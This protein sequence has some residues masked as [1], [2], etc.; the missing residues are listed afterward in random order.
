MT[1]VSSI[2]TNY[3]K[4]IVFV[5]QKNELFRITYSCTKFTNILLN[6]AASP[7]TLPKFNVYQILSCSIN[8]NKY[9][10]NIF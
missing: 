5:H 4:K 2:L 10:L 1:S 9:K 8:Y 7:L 6:F 3:S